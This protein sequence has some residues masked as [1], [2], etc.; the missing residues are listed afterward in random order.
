MGIPGVAGAPVTLAHAFQRLVGELADHFGQQG[1][2]RVDQD[3]QVRVL[4]GPC[5]RRLL[6]PVEQA[7]ERPRVR[8][9]HRG[10]RRPGRSIVAEPLPQQP[11]HALPEH[12]CLRGVDV[13]DRPYEQVQARRG[14]DLLPH[15]LLRHGLPDERVPRLTD[16]GQG[17]LP[18]PPRNGL[19]PVPETDGHE[20][21]PRREQGPGQ[22]VGAVPAR[23]QGPTL[24]PAERLPPVLGRQLRPV[25]PSV[26]KHR[27]AVEDRGP[28]PQRGTHLDR[29]RLDGDRRLPRN[30]PLGPEIGLG[31]AP[32]ARVEP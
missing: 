2:R 30:Q 13:G 18:Y 32:Q 31:D 3:P 29:R 26:G 20:R 19:S 11:A 25:R 23:D 5:D 7:F 17:G 21:V 14:Q 15:R 9:Q 24:H 12:R 16:P 1:V 28:G 22:L 6:D 4:R 27:V 10:G 8:G